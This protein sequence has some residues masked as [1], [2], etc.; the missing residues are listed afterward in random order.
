PRTTR[1]EKVA[2]VEPAAPPADWKSLARDGAFEDAYGR[3]QSSAVKP[4]S[5]VEELFL[6]ADV[7]RL[8]GHPAEA[9]PH[10]RRILAEHPGDPRVAISAFTLGR[11]LLDDLGRPN[12]AATA[13]ALAR[14]AAPDGP[15]EEDALAREVE[16]WSRAGDTDRAADLA[17][18]YVAHHPDGH[19]I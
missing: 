12:E 13:F 7:A 18:E 19:R 14:Q 3:L 17:R 9:V 2:T 15:L 4:A 8:S 5:T 10:L 6:A 1:P 16:A 11:I